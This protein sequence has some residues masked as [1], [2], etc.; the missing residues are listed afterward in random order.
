MTR[1][2]RNPETTG[3]DRNVHL[4]KQEEVF[5][6]PPSTHDP[7]A[8]CVSRVGRWSTSGDVGGEGAGLSIRSTTPGEEPGSI[9]T[10]EIQRYREI[11]TERY[12]GWLGGMPGERGG[13][14]LFI[15]Y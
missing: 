8:T 14:R 1:L 9:G 3:G 13:S 2:Q 7:Q 4:K 15:F 12:A 5:R 6:Y 10:Y 11:G